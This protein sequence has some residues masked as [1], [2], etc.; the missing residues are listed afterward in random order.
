VV[1]KEVLVQNSTGIHARPAS[2]FVNKA[3]EFDSDIK[4]IKDNEEVNAKSIMMIMA[5]GIAKGSN[6]KIQASGDDEAKAV[7]ELV[8]LV[9]SKFG[10]E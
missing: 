6:I 2:L 1:A 5:A 4:I 7:E 9:N 8:E 10:E 3:Q